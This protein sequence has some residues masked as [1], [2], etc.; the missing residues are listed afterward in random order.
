M[1]LNLAMAGFGFFLASALALIVEKA[2]DRE[3]YPKNLNKGK[4]EYY[5]FLLAGLILLNTAVF[6]LLAVS[7]RYA[8]HGNRAQEGS[9]V[10][11]GLEKDA[12][13]SDQE[14]D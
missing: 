7:Y 1:G 4:L 8:D 10:Q 11:I 3:W 14:E 12:S 6:L 9:R 5:M 13:Y 2:S